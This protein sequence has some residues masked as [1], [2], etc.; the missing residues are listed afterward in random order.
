MMM[1]I[2]ILLYLTPL[3]VHFI[4]APESAFWDQFKGEGGFQIS[5]GLKNKP[6]QPDLIAFNPSSPTTTTITTNNNSNSSSNNKSSSIVMG[7]T[8]FVS[9]P[10]QNEVPLAGT[11]SKKGETMM[12]FSDSKTRRPST[13]GIHHQVLR[14]YGLEGGYLQQQTSSSSTS[15]SATAIAAAIAAETG[16]SKS[17]GKRVGYANSATIHRNPI[18]NNSSSSAGGGAGGIR[19]SPSD[20]NRPSPVRVFV[21]F[22]PILNTERTIYVSPNNATTT[23]YSSP[24][25]PSSSSSSP[26]QLSQQTNRNYNRSLSE[27]LNIH[28]T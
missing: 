28:S 6:S 9:L 13:Q 3:P 1:S 22:N 8:T 5:K 14:P 18:S 19:S 21:S 24:G 10:Y 16:R 20:D 4:L 27:V 7:D 25:L 2:Y 12:F 15:S 17:A 11:P 26:Q 23:S